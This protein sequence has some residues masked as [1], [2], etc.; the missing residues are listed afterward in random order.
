MTPDLYE[1]L[2]GFKEYTL[3]PEP[4]EILQ[5]PPMWVQWWRWG[6]SNDYWRHCWP[7]QLEDMVLQ[8][9]VIVAAWKLACDDG[10]RRLDNIHSWWD[11]ARPFPIQRK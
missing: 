7:S 4:W 6:Q 3:E 2:R 9:E 1:A 10:E 5:N 8:A 11:T